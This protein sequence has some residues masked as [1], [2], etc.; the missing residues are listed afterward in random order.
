[1]YQ[2][3]S[4]DE[5]LAA[6]RELARKEGLAALQIRS[7]AAQ[8]RI[9][10]GSVYH[11]FPNKTELLAAVVAS[12]W[13]EVFQNSASSPAEQ[14]FCIYLETLFQK[15]KKGAEQYPGFFTA[16]QEIFSESGK[17]TALKQRQQV[18]DHIRQD[19]L[20]ALEQDPLISPEI[21]SPPLTKESLT[22]LAFRYLLLLLAE[23]AADCCV[24]TSLLRRAL[25][26]PK[27][28]DAPW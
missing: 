20:N 5:I 28:G 11:Y 18:L 13:Q 8:A 26:V 10:I 6:A 9:S 21:F 27:A 3:T 2:T 23:N 14:D 17:D 24:L 16:H 7:I 4:K 1:M 12:L 19:L 15:L 22:E 25:Y